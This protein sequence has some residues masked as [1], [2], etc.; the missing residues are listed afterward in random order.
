MA[1]IALATSSS[2]RG[3]PYARPTFENAMLHSSSPEQLVPVI[4]SVY[5]GNEHTLRL[6]KLTSSIWRHRNGR[7]IEECTSRLLARVTL[8]F[9]DLTV[10]TPF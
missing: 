2:F 10:C 8:S 1:R 4:I 9:F 3:L 5:A 7:K 6:V